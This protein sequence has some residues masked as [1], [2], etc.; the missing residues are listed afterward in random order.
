MLCFFGKGG[1]VGVWGIGFSKGDCF[2]D[3][4]D[5]G[6]KYRSLGV[7]LDLHRLFV[8]E[9]FRACGFRKVREFSVVGL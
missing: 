3:F 9:R 1:F 7:N 5:K 2:R 6:L 8:V 4:R